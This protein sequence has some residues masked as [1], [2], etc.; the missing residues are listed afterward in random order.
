V[1]ELDV[2]RF[3]RAELIEDGEALVEDGAAGEREAVL[4]EVADGHAADVGALAVVERLD[5]GEDFEERGFAGAVSADEAGALVGR[6][7]PVDV[8]EEQFGAE[9]LAGGG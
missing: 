3:Q 5:A 8:V 4:R 1:G 7:E 9:A 6:D 2:F